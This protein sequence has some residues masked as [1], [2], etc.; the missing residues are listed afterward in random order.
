M[1]TNSRHKPGHGGSRVEEPKEGLRDKTAEFTNG[2]EGAPR[3]VKSKQVG[4]RGKQKETKD[5]SSNNKKGDVDP[6][7]PSKSPQE[8]QAPSGAD[9]K[10][11]KDKPKKTADN[12][13]LMSAED[14]VLVVR[15]KLEKIIHGREKDEKKALNLMRVLERT[16]ISKDLVEST[17]IDLTLE[18]MRFVIKDP[19]IKN[20]TE[21]VLRKLKP[22]QVKKDLREI[23]STG[24]RD[25]KKPEED[26]SAEDDGLPSMRIGYWMDKLMNGGKNLDALNKQLDNLSKEVKT[27]VPPTPEKK[28]EVK[29]PTVDELVA[30][31]DKK[32]ENALDDLAAGLDNMLLEDKEKENK[33]REDKTKKET[34]KED[35]IDKIL[36]EDRKKENKKREEKKTRETERELC[37]TSEIDQ[38]CA[39]VSGV[40]L[41]HK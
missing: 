24:W 3:S 15:H 21:K 18:A 39:K 4:P 32:T 40:T 14:Q 30:I 37:I 23:A 1:G 7:V 10:K 27:V 20:K 16:D 17:K 33:K 36:L 11:T 29:T 34:K 8:N 6:K 28:E 25:S 13:N 9:K 5:A 35:E 41:E 31:P 22:P 2:R 26:K 38:I 19:A 12:F